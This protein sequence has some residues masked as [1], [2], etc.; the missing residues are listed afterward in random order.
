MDTVKV[1]R[2]KWVGGSSI[3]T[4]LNVNKF[5][6][7]YELLL[8]MAHIVENKFTGNAYTEYGNEMEPIIRDHINKILETN[9]VPD[10]AYKQPYRGNC[11]GIFEDSI[12]EIKTSSN[13]DW[14][15]YELQTQLYMDMFNCTKGVIAVYERPT[16]FSIVF[17]ETRLTIKFI[18]RDEDMLREIHQSVDEFL[19][20]LERMKEAFIFGEVLTELDLADSNELTTLSA[21]LVSL[22][23]QLVNM[24]AIEKRI[25]E[26]KTELKEQMEINELKSFQTPSGIKVTL[27]NDKPD[28][29]IEVFDQGLFEEK[30]PAIVNECTVMKP[31]IE[32]DSVQAFAT[33][34]QLKE[35]S[36]Q[37]IKKGRKGYVKITLP[38]GK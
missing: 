27:V 7:R 14:Y 5:K 1:D 31:V 18:E 2:D 28:E 30:Y 9:F 26:L 6:T 20:D 38:K 15:A 33:D 12:L 4:I 10:V 37:Q 35:C 17:D 23:T 32:W 36:V 19:K 16:N 21:E 29:Q 8:E 3:P 24:K 11:D 34:E 13:P 22:E 25:K